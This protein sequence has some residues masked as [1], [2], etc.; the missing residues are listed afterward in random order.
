MEAMGSGAYDEQ[1]HTANVWYTA[2]IECQL[3]AQDVSAL[4]AICC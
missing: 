4:S 3:M 2:P 1:C